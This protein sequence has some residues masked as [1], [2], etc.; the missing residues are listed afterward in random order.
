MSQPTEQRI[1]VYVTPHDGKTLVECSLCGPV[2]VT[3]ALPEPA[4][5]SHMAEHAVHDPVQAQ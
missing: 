4:A 5:R 2:A 1:N 3:T